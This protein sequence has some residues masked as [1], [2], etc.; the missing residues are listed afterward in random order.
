MR[1]QLVTIHDVARAAGVSPATVSRVFNGGK[2]TPARALSVQEAAAA[3]GFAP[4][5]VARSLRKQ[6]SSVIALIIPDIEN[7]FFTSLARGVEDAAQRTSLSVV[8]CNSDEDTEKERRYLEVA[9]GEQ[10]AGVIV[11]AASQDE[12]DLGPLTDRGVPVVAVDRR[13]RDAEVDAVRVDNHHGGEVATR[14]LLQAGY[15]RIACIT[16]PEGAS[17][18]EERL[19]GHRAALSAAQGGAAAADNTYI[20]HADFR[21][22]GGRVAMRE[23]LALPE[24]PDAVFVAN[25][26][27][28]IGVLDALGEAGRTPPGVGVLSFGDVPWASLVRPSLTAVELPSYELGRTAAD[29]LLQRRDGSLSPVQTVVL[30]TKLQVR[31]S[32]AGPAGS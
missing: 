12:T 29:L 32:T 23:L 21:V 25:N 24:P 26:L 20:R 11:A 31:E 14:H 18:S 28:T 6:R 17:T 1:T 8:L 3:L 27:M 10:M 2:V 22:E 5:R 13:P 30:R 15:R 19:A 7:P 9:L 16:G 4:N